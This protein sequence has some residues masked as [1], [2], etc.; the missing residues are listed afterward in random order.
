MKIIGKTKDYYDSALGF[1][2]DDSC[3]Y[4]RKRSL[5][6]AH[7]SPDILPWK[8][9]NTIP[10][11]YFGEQGQ[12]TLSVV[13]TSLP[14]YQGIYQ[15]VRFHEAFV[16]VA[17]QAYGVF[18]RQ[19]GIWPVLPE[20]TPI[21]GH[22]E[23][24]KILNLFPE[25]TLSNGTPRY[26]VVDNFLSFSDAARSSYTH[27]RDQFLSRDFTSLHLQMGAPVLLILN[28]HHFQSHHTTLSDNVVV[29]NN[30][31]LKDLHMQ[32]VLDPFGC[33]QSIEQFISGVVPGQQMPMVTLTDQD[34]VRKKGFDPKYGFRTRPQK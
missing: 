12:R 28:P 33:F 24:N 17:G 29:V 3:V 23:A 21:V 19:Q 34:M 30:P 14:K 26:A 18:V 10:P 13:E 1:G 4:V 6:T 11:H 2:H 22:S 16:C 9:H 31:V 5:N 7:I 27:T 25:Q 8:R 15:S 32:N 20:T